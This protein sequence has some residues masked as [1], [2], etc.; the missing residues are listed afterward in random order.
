[1]VSKNK[2]NRK[3]EL[4]SQKQ[5]NVIS[6][7]DLNPKAYEGQ[8]TSSPWGSSIYDGDKFWG[9]FGETQ[10][11]NIDYWTL[12]QRSSQLF[13]ENLYA[14]G[15]IRR[16]VTNE[17]TTGLSPEVLPEEKIIGVPDDSLNDWTDDVETRFSLWAEN[18]QL[19]DFNGQET[20]GSLQQSAR[21]EALVS[22][23]VLVV[24]RQSKITKLSA[25]YE[26]RNPYNFKNL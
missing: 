13:N 2:K 11:Q 5:D 20:F 7:D 1:M 4:A 24:L 9:G 17:I 19:C 8:H 6:V 14:R 15:L 25:K 21:M 3:R 18:P 12:R 22:G 26:L 23:D 16:L 10:L